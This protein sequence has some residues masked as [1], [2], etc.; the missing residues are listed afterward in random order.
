MDIERVSI[1]ESVKFALRKLEDMQCSEAA[2]LSG[3]TALSGV[4]SEMQCLQEMLVQIDQ[5]IMNDQVHWENTD[6]TKV[7][8]FT[9]ELEDVS[10]L[11][12]RAILKFMRKVGS[13]KSTA[14]PVIFKRI[15]PKPVDF[16]ALHK[17]KADIRE[18]KSSG[19]RINIKDLGEP[20]ERSIPRP[21]RQSIQ[22]VDKIW[23][24]GLEMHWKCILQ[25]VL[26]KSLPT[27][28]V[29]QVV[30]S[31]TFARTV[32]AEKIYQRFYFKNF[33]III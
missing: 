4:L 7:Q 2:A 16:F 18:I 10:T 6:D 3:A 5:F 12:E 11:I 26:D 31:E 33:H 27:R 21:D 20:N 19:A 24:L 13:I 32:L 28:F 29:V 22:N 17:L 9:T 8:K 30:G 25:K 23:F 1:P 14:I 15:D